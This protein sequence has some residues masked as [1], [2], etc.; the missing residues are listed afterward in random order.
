MASINTWT[1]KCNSYIRNAEKTTNPRICHEA[2]HTY[3]SF[4]EFSRSSIDTRRWRVDKNYLIPNSYYHLVTEI[5]FFAD[6]VKLSRHSRANVLQIGLGGGTVNGFLHY[7][8]P[9]MNITVVEISAQMISLARKWHD[10]R[11]DDHHRVIH[12]DGVRFLKK[13]VEEGESDC[14]P[15]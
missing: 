1:K 11:I 5:L 8:F 3:V 4:A 15:T 10:L 12:A 14:I 7:N 2:F 13:Q 6:A 9:E